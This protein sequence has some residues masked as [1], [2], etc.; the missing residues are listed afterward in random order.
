VKPGRGS[1]QQT[2]RRSPFVVSYWLGPA[3]V[4][5]N[6]LT[7][8]RDAGDPFVAEF[9]YF[10][11]QGKTFDELME[12]FPEQRE[13][14]LRAGVRQLLKRSL[15]E[16][17]ASTAIE[18]G[19]AGNRGIQRPVISTSRR[20]TRNLKRAKATTGVGCEPSPGCDP[21]LQR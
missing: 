21:F 1:K 3:L 12:W 19:Q 17:Y 8:Q 16:T 9:L 7:R 2:Y 14:T 13:R 10:C 6:Y 11:G 15:L 5:E 18:S 4:F 20:K